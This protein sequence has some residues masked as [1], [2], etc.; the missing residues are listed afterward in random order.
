M[1]KKVLRKGSHLANSCKNASREWSCTKNNIFCACFFFLAS[2]VKVY[3]SVR[4]LLSF[5]HVTFSTPAQVQTRWLRRR[6][7]RCPIF[8]PTGLFFARKGIPGN[9]TEQKES[10]I[11]YLRSVC[12][13]KQSVFSLTFSG[14]PPTATL[15]TFFWALDLPAH[16]HSCL[17]S[18]IFPRTHILRYGEAAFLEPYIHTSKVKKGRGVMAV[19]LHVAS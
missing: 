19:W 2:A 10:F 7:R 16:P 6:R 17:R 8:A 14:Q 5:S 4:C 11:L 1:K 12:L 13:Q 9:I 18:F 15:L 3:V